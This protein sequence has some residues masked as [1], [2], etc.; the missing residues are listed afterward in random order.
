MTRVYTEKNVRAA[1]PE[2]CKHPVME[3][4][5][6]TSRSYGSV[7]SWQVCPLCKTQYNN[8]CYQDY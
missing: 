4:P 7:Y 6:E 8:S 5:W 2:L 3:V 1:S